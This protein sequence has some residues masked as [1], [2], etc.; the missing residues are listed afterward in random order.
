MLLDFAD[1]Y[2][3]TLRAVVCEEFGD[4]NILEIMLKYL[5]MWIFQSLNCID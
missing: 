1:F 4:F 2:L 5:H 3:Y